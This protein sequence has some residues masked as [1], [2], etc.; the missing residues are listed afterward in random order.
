MIGNG[1]I[2][3]IKKK[4]DDHLLKHNDYN[5]YIMLI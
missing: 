4:K 1:K 5:Y 2:S 3:E